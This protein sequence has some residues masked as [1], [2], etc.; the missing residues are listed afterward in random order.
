[1]VLSS[2]SNNFCYTPLF[3]SKSMVKG[4]YFKLRIM[5]RNGEKPLVSL[6]A[7]MSYCWDMQSNFPSSFSLQLFLF[8]CSS[9]RIV[10][11]KTG[12]GSMKAIELFLYVVPKREVQRLKIKLWYLSL[13]S[14]PVSFLCS[15][16][17]SYPVGKSFSVRKV[18]TYVT[19]ESNW[20]CEKLSRYSD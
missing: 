11:R 10:F 7:S 4:K 16:L 9:P 15:A 12:I 18:V 6:K 2:K 1:M 3:C 19:H 13:S 20:K 17:C 8:L 5:N 14:S